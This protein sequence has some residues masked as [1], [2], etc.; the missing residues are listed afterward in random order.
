[1]PL[2]SRSPLLFW[3]MAPVAL[4]AAVALPWVWERW[5]PSGSLVLAGVEAALVLLVVTLWDPVRF[6]WAGR[7]L[8]ALVAAGLV[9]FLLEAEGID[10]AHPWP[11]SVFGALVVVV[12]LHYVVTGRWERL[13][14]PTD[15]RRSWSGEATL[16]GRRLRY[17]HGDEVWELHRD[18][19]L[20]VGELTVEAHPADD[21]F[22]CFVTDPDGEWRSLSFY[23]VGEADVLE[24]LSEELGGSFEHGLCNSVS[25]RSRTMWPPDLAGEPLFA[26]APLP[27]PASWKERLLDFAKLRSEPIVVAP[28]VLEALRR[29]ASGDE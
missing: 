3:L 13:E 17:Q 2:F 16:H 21:Y 14:D 22:L 5:S 15:V 19:I 26:R 28:G 6:H 25:F 27:P 12:C 18:D 4:P 9:A 29:R 7:A 1:M 20:A 10:A 11:M 8:I 24:W 23:A